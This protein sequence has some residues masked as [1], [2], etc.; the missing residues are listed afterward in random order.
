M[1]R[2][3]GKVAWIT[4]AG[5][6]IARAAA[7]IFCAEGAKVIIAEL[8]EQLGQAAADEVNTAGGDARFVST[9]VT[10]E[11]SVEASIAE[12]IGAYGRLDVLYNCAGGSIAEDK[13]VTEVDL[14]AVWDFTM[15]LDLK[16]PMLGAKYGIPHLIEGGGGSVINM[17]SVAALRGNFAG[18]VYSAAKGGVIGLTRS[19]AGRYSRWNIR[20]NAIAPGLILTDR[21]T[22]RMNIDAGAGYDE[23]YEAATGGQ[24]KRYPFGVGAAA[25]IANVALFLASD[26]SRMVNGAT[27]PAEGGLS[28]Y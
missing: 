20:S 15:P 8:N 24:M 17:T 19:L 16:G 28:V 18:H 6:G 12:A 4:G 5:S 26:E 21:V 25:D 23:Q 14:D 3:D 9:D 10:D 7:G 11:A 1:G 22:G 13:A 2:L 27:I